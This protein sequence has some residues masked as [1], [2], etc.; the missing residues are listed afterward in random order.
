MIGSSPTG[1][2]GAGSGPKLRDVQPPSSSRELKSAQGTGGLVGQKRGRPSEG[3]ERAGKQPLGPLQPEAGNTGRMAGHATDSQLA[4][5]P[6][7]EAWDQHKKL[8]KKIELLRAKLREAGDEAAMASRQRDEAA[9][10]A[11]RLTSDNARQAKSLA[12]ANAQLAALQQQIK[13]S[14]QPDKVK[15]L[16]SKVLALEEENAQLKAQQ[17]FPLKTL[18]ESPDSRAGSPS[19]TLPGKATSPGSGAVAQP[20]LTP[21]D[22]ETPQLNPKA[23]AEARLNRLEARVLKLQ[24]ERDSA[25]SR[26]DRLR[27]CIDDLWGLGAA[28]SYICA[29]SGNSARGGGLAPW[30][31]TTVPTGTENPRETALRVRLAAMQRALARAE[32]STGTA[33]PASKYVASLARRRALSQRVATLEAEVAA[34]TAAKS[35][36]QQLRQQ[37]GQLEAT[38]AQVRKQLEVAKAGAKR[39]VSEGE[40]LRDLEAEMAKRESQEAALRSALASSEARIAELEQTLGPGVEETL[41]ALRAKAAELQTENMEL[42]AELDALDPEFFEELEDLKHEHHV[43]KRRCQELQGHLLRLCADTGHSLP[44]SLS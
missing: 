33:V 5:H 22:S 21:G 18:P 15:Q 19:R 36:A 10:K 1:S 2:V 39:V 24:A 3:G 29:P 41:A 11:S 12:E 34:S 30:R 31:P 32:Q 17:P 4:G 9:A 26:C 38:V 6:H 37:V 28:D 43:F 27:D 8:Q 13:L 7:L 16:V 23:S 35:E 44:L 25:M 40:R 20:P 42:R 14:V